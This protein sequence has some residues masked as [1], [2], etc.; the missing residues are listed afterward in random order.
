MAEGTNWRTASHTLKVPSAFTS[1]SWRGSATEVVTATCAARCR[2]TSG[3]AVLKVSATRLKSR[4]WPVTRWKSPVSRSHSRFF[5]APGR[6]R[7]SNTTTGCLCCM[8]HRATLEP[9][10]PAP[11][12]INHFMGVSPLRGFA[13][14]GLRA[15]RRGAVSHVLQRR[16][17]RA[18][19]NSEAVGGLDP[20]LCRLPETAAFA[21]L[22]KQTLDCTRD[23]GRV[24]G[25]DQLAAICKVQPLST[26]A[27]GHDRS[28]ERCG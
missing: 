8:R 22:E 5:A 16:R 17:D 27:G 15:R 13:A 9:M 10:K 23:V 4:M 26:D 1:K 24:V 20:T 3:L 19:Q 21:G 7:L 18:S 6:E 28:P 11:P 14:F 25:E 12:V 2:T